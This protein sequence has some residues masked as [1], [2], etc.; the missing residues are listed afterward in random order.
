MH[1]LRHLRRTEQRIDYKIAMF[2]KN[3]TVI[4]FFI[5]FVLVPLFVLSAVCISTMV[6]MNILFSVF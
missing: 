1:I 4:G 6:I 2:A 3:H 5:L